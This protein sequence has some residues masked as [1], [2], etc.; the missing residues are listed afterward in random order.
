VY[1]SGGAPPFSPFRVQSCVA[2]GPR[3]GARVGRLGDAADRGLVTSR[4]PR[5]AQ[6]EGFDLHANVWVP[7]NDR[8]RLEQLC[9]Y[10][11]RP[12]LAQDR[13]RLRADGRILV[14]LKPVW[15]DG[16]A[17]RLFE[18]IE[19]MEKL[20]AIHPRAR[21]MELT[22]YDPELDPQRVGAARLTTLLEEVLAG[23]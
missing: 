12:P 2:L 19:F 18:P 11:L 22:I 15:R 8:A 20:A 23:A 10:L 4:G 16:T 21:G 3:S 1:R 9:R 6:L 13:V 14:E 5:Q 7:R 17:Q